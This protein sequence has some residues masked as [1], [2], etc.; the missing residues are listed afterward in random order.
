MSAAAEKEKWSSIEE[1]A[2]HI[3]V[4]KDTIR[5]WIKNKTIPAHRVGKLWKFKLSEVDEYI[6]SGA[7][8]EPTVAADEE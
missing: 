6:L 1:V 2:D 5:N 8:A 7:A 4:T 3:G